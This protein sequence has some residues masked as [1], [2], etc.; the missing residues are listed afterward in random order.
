MRLWEERG[1]DARAVAQSALTTTPWGAFFWTF[2]VPLNRQNCRRR[3][4]AVSFGAAAGR[5]SARHPSS[6][7]T[8]FHIC[9]PA[10]KERACS[11]QRKRMHMWPS[12]KERAARPARESGGRRD[13]CLQC[14]DSFASFSLQAARADGLMTLEDHC[15]ATL[16][17]L[18]RPLQ[19]LGG[20]PTE[21]GRP[22]PSAGKMGDLSR[23]LGSARQQRSPDSSR[24]LVTH[25]RGPPPRD[26]LRWGPWESP[27][28][29]DS[30]DWGRLRLGEKNA[31][32]PPCLLV[33]SPPRA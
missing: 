17:R 20:G 18:S 1:D 8:I 7:K 3:G 30:Q 9:C 14:V 13:G 10:T 32:T 21:D 28:P 6:R 11:L 19:R 4:D 33:S 25:L 29:R 22:K 24:H 12:R 31:A 23:H 27:L 2:S 26:G 15:L 16:V 5:K